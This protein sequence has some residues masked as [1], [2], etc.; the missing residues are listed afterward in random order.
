MP[1]DLSLAIDGL[2]AAGQQG[3]RTRFLDACKP[4]PEALLFEAAALVRWSSL[5]FRALEPGWRAAMEQRLELAD[6]CLTAYRRRAA[7]SAT[8]AT[9]AVPAGTDVDAAAAGER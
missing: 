6:R 5:P 4:G 1:L 7:T 3:A 2:A 9:R 8:S